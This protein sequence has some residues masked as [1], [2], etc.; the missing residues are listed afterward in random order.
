MTPYTNTLLNTDSNPNTTPDHL[1]TLPGKLKRISFSVSGFSLSLILEQHF[2]EVLLFLQALWL[3]NKFL[4]ETVNTEDLFA[5]VFLFYRLKKKKS[6]HA[7]TQTADLS[8]RRV[9]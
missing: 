8:Q 3:P 1:T 2:L 9:L 6:G 4:Q 5:S 7:Q